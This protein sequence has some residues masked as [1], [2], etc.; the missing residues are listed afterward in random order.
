MI[1]RSETPYPPI[2]PITSAN[3]KVIAIPFDIDRVV[4]EVCTP[5]TARPRF[6]CHDYVTGKAPECGW[7]AERVSPNFWGLYPSQ[8]RT[9][10][11]QRSDRSS[12]HDRTPWSA[13]H[14]SNTSIV[15][16]AYTLPA[17]DFT[18]RIA[19]LNVDSLRM[20]HGV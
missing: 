3:H 14:R 19:H 6:R 11:Q 4:T 13:D 2:I 10:G 9:I 17:T 5:G 7:K 1:F 15:F 8:V 12:L 18:V 16:E 20:R